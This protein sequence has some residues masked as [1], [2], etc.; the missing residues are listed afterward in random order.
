MPV[1]AGVPATPLPVLTA[2]PGLEQ[3]GRP[4]FWGGWG[5]AVVIL[6]PFTRVTPAIA[7]IGIRGFLVAGSM[8]MV[9]RGA[10]RVR[11][12]LAPG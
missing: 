12:W 11:P 6:S 4:P 5:W 2:E 7:S 1:P 10:W 3:G 8:G 9:D